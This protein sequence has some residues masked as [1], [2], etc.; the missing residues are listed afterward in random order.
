MTNYF[1]F[2]RD[3]HLSK[4]WL[5]D[6]RFA[7]LNQYKLMHKEMAGFK[8]NITL[9]S[10]SENITDSTIPIYFKHFLLY[11]NPN[12][13]LIRLKRIFFLQTE[14]RKVIGADNFLQICPSTK[15]LFPFLE[16]YHNEVMKIAAFVNNF[17]NIIYNN[18]AV[19][20]RL[21]QW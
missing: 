11:T 10:P 12:Y 5:I 15:D 6:L 8:L 4:F 18:N 17:F 21:P 2:N 13:R 7:S 9:S 1:N 14:F 16:K 20:E 3:D 19:L